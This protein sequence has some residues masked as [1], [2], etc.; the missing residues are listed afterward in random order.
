MKTAI[1]ALFVA[2]SSAQEGS[3]QTKVLGAPRAAPTVNPWQCE[4]TCPPFPAGVCTDDGLMTKDAVILLQL[5]EVS[6][7][8]FTTGQEVPRPAYQKRGVS[9]EVRW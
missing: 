6:Q 9:Q 8:H 2:L 1:I 4:Q 5:G 3:N 7:T